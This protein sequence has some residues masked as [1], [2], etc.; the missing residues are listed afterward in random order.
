MNTLLTGLHQFAAT[1]QTTATKTCISGSDIGV[2]KTALDQAALNNALNTT[3][4]VIGSLSVLFIIIGGMRYI[5]SAGDMN[6]VKAAKDTI[7]YAVIGLVVTT[8]A[9]L[10][11]QLVLGVF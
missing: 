9:F 10:I 11:V 8:L 2:P 3:F 5:L 6:Q 4:L 1:C 7:L